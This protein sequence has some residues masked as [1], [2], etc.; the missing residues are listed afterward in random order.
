[1]KTNNNNISYLVQQVKEQDSQAFTLLYEDSYQKIFFYALCLLQNHEEAE[2]ALLEIYTTILSSIDSVRNESLFVPWSYKVA[3]SV[4]TRM[5]S[6][7]KILLLDDNISNDFLE[8]I[9]TSIQNENEALMAQAVLRLDDSLRSTIIL[10]DYHSMR[11]KDIAL[12]MSCPEGTVKRRLKAAKTQLRNIL[13]KQN[14]LVLYTTIPIAIAMGSA[15]GMGLSKEKAINIL[16]KVLLR[17]ALSPEFEFTPQGVYKGTGEIQKASYRAFFVGAFSS[18]LIILAGVFFTCEPEIWAIY[19]SSTAYVQSMDLDFTIKSFLPLKTVYLSS[20]TGERIELTKVSERTYRAT[21]DKNGVYTARATALNQKT[22]T[23]SID[24]K[25]IDT[26]PPYIKEYSLKDDL[27]YVKYGDNASGV[28]FELLY[29]EEANRSVLYPLKS[30][31]ESAVFQINDT[32]Y[33]LY[34]T[35][36]AGNQEEIK[37]NIVE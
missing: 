15:A 11:T 6:S 30:D 34:I 32:I 10:H 2:K 12:I 17:N 31:G 24:V 16:T 14:L 37:I 27:L 20:L 13:E 26:S 18:L 29:L 8:H 35:D 4:C 28:A 1:M 19:P 5:I 9:Y 33:S 21:V 3:H 36:R 25:N 7:K 22:T 23:Q